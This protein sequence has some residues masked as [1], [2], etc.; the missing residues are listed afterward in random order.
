MRTLLGLVTAATLAVAGLTACSPDAAGGDALKVGASPVPHAQILQLI[1]RDL[2]DK[3]GLDLEIVEFTDYVQPN[4]AL[5]EGQIDANF[6]QHVPYL[7]EQNKEGGYDCAALA[8]V[9]IEPLGVYSK[10]VKKLADTPRN[11][12]V[13]IPNDPTNA[14]RA[15]QLLGANGLLTLKPGAGTAA[16]KAD[17][18]DNPKGLKITELEA[19]QLPRSLAD[20]DLSVINGNYALE[21][22]LT[23]SKDAVALESGAGNPYANLL[24]TTVAKKNDAKIAKLEQLLHSP[25]VKKYIETEFKGTVLPAF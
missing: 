23:P 21:A 6:F 16:T 20:T 5:K 12:V 24:V 11:A 8:P 7:E 17:I 4:V 9:H 22:G 10:K 18:A 25:E 3:A 14:G 19:A 15:L 1:K 2:A 13:A